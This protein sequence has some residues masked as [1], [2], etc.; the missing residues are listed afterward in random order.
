M[1]SCEGTG[2]SDALYTP[3]RDLVLLGD[4]LRC[5]LPAVRP[6]LERMFEDRDVE[7]LLDDGRQICRRRIFSGGSW[8]LD[9]TPAFPSPMKIGLG[10]E[11]RESKG[12]TMTLS[13]LCGPGGGWVN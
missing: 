12:E 8:S 5:L 7:D 3:P 4:R 10:V 9:V 1:E 11:I 13:T 6:L 2:D